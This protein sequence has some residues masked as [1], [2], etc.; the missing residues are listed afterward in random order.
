MSTLLRDV[1]ID[2]NYMSRTTSVCYALLIIN[3]S[4]L[5]VAKIHYCKSMQA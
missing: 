2:Q 4:A 1:V 5:R 3:N